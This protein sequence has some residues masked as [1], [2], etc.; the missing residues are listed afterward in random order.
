MK[1]FLHQTRIHLTCLCRS[2]F[3]LPLWLKPLCLH[4][5]WGPASLSENWSLYCH[6]STA[7][8]SIWSWIPPMR[9]RVVIGSDCKVNMEWIFKISKEITFPNTLKHLLFSRYPII[10]PR[11]KCAGD[12]GDQPGVRSYGLRPANEKYDV[13]CYI[14]GLKGKSWQNSDITDF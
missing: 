2:G 13:Y 3:P 7:A 10:F 11:D 9:C 6:A 14:E 1:E 8:G 5:C 12:L 4:L